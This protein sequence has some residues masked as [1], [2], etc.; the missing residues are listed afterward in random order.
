MPYFSATL[1]STVGAGFAEH[2]PKRT[3]NNH[4]FIVHSNHDYGASRR[5]Q[6]AIAH[7]AR[8]SRMTAP[9]HPLTTIALRKNYGTL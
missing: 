9:K 5:K 8:Q 2:P 7:K 3:I 4:F 6:R 1:G